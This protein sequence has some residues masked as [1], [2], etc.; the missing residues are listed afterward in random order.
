ME[1]LYTYLISSQVILILLIP[2]STLTTLACHSYFF[3]NL[4][5]GNL[6][7][8]LDPTCILCLEPLTTISLTYFMPQGIML[9][10][11]KLLLFIHFE[12]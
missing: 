3:I 10:Y 5:I 12:P 9:K 11:M 6:I 4:L 7:F 1:L 2:R 8:I